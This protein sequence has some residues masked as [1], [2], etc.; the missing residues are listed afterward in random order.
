MNPEA[1][2][3][4][5]KANYPRDVRKGLVKSMLAVEKGEDRDALQQ[6]YSLINQIFSYVL[7][8]CNWSMPSNSHELDARPLEIMKETFPKLETTRWYQEQAL[9]A[10]RSIEL[11]SDDKQ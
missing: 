3:E 9:I 5:L 2:I 4:F 6:Q 11:R 1:T 8:E 7:K 10:K